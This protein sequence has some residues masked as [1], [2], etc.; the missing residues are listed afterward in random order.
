[1]LLT[2]LE[3]RDVG[4]FRGRHV[5]ELRPLGAHRPIVLVAGSNGAGKTTLLEIVRLC[6]YGRRALGGRIAEADYQE[7]L[8]QL[9]HVDLGS[10]AQAT[11]E[12]ALSFEQVRSGTRTVYRVHRLWRRRGRR[13][14]EE[15]EVRRDGQ[16]V[17]DTDASRWQD[18]LYQLLPPALAE[19]SFFDAERIRD[20]ADDAA[21]L[22][23][24]SSIRSLLGLDTV[25]RLQDDLSLYL[26]RQGRSGQDGLQVEIAQLDEQ[27]RKRAA[28]AEALDV[29]MRAAQRQLRASERKLAAVED[30]L[31]RQGGSAYARRAELNARAQQLEASQR[32]ASEELAELC[33][34]PL[35]LA[36]APLLLGRAQAALETERQ[37]RM[38]TMQ[39]GAARRLL[40]Q[41]RGAG[42]DHVWRG[43]AERLGL[44]PAQL[45]GLLSVVTR[46]L[47][48]SATQK[49]ALPTL[50][51]R[52][53]DEALDVLRRVA[54]EAERARRVAIRLRDVKRQRQRTAD[55]LDRAP[56]PARIEPLLNELRQ[57]HSELET[58]QAKIAQLRAKLDEL[59][60]DNRSV[61]AHVRRL[62]DE[63]RQALSQEQQVDLALR[64]R[65]ALSMFGERLAAARL[66]A[67]ESAVQRNLAELLVSPLVAAVHI[68]RKSFAVALIDSRG[69]RIER[70]SMSA[71][72][73]QIYAMAFMLALA[74][75]S[76]RRLPLI[77]DSPLG[78]LDKAH[79][80]RL[81][82]S[83]F[84]HAAD[85]VVILT[86]DS[87]LDEELGTLIAPSVSRSFLLDHDR[88]S[89]T[90]VVAPNPAPIST[91]ASAIQDRHHVQPEA[92][93]I[94]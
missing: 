36:M 7:R 78:R 70:E 53:Q 4:P 13:V 12:A 6:L 60:S 34:G 76:R 91:S 45:E 94:R 81:A 18:F 54:P 59:A 66:S 93:S 38:D 19:L 72:Q 5:I 35:P 2:S 20:L 23:M 3:L 37:Q 47:A 40:R 15:L 51:L 39:A 14:T 21:G 25:G 1:M 89:R 92:L 67:I 8:R 33:A 56:E 85:Q 83:Y 73:R 22:E 48:P 69:R 63:A 30:E 41:L 61:D 80:R 44:T 62:S 9:F 28:T 49:P 57:R 55:E 87:E 58:L 52:S 68:D 24:A 16:I 65:A 84:P 82:E 75:T 29:Q 86:T 88:A 50:Q 71:G 74:Q 31:T 17:A 27:R 11:V 64:V 26:A 46:R 32:L 42:K 43:E 10:Q 77:I 90:T 79:R